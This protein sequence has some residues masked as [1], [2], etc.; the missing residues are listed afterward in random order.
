MFP[1]SRVQRI[2]HHQIA[3][4]AKHRIDHS[5]GFQFDKQSSLDQNTIQNDDPNMNHNIHHKL[6]PSQSK[7]QVIHVLVRKLIK[8]FRCVDSCVCL[9]VNIQGNYHLMMYSLR[10]PLKMEFHSVPN[11]IAFLFQ[12]SHQCNQEYDKLTEH[13]C[14]QSNRH[15]LY[16][17]YH[18]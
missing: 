10:R 5:L 7:G 3:A 16:K 13:Q 2:C 6:N 17:G 4:N 14:L 15:K 1:A 12:K 9:L 8:H 18:I 11:S